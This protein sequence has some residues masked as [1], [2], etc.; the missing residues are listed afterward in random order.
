MSRIGFAA[1]FET[2]DCSHVI[3]PPS[4]NSTA[5]D[6]FS[7]SNVDRDAGLVAAPSTS[8]SRS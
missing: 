8:T 4:R 7:G 5:A 1:A 6:V 3:V 2:E